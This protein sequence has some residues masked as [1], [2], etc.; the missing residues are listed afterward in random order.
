MKL[1]KTTALFFGTKI[2]SKLREALSQSKTGDK[3]YFDG[4]SEEFLRILEI[5]D[6]K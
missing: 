3:K 1:D 2:D 5:E 6:E 4:T